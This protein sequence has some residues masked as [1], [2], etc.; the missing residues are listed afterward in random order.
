MLEG[1]LKGRGVIAPINLTL[2]PD[3]RPEWKTMYQYDPDKSRALLA[4]MGWDSNRVV[5]VTLTN[6]RDDR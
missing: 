6:P 2:N 5:E 3:A 4:D 1:I